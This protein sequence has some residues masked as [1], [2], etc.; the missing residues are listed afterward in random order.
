MRVEFVGGTHG[1][2]MRRAPINRRLDPP[3]IPYHT[4]IQFHLITVGNRHGY[5]T[6][7]NGFL[8]VCDVKYKFERFSTDFRTVFEREG[9]FCWILF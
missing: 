3:L 4:I 1:G 6:A 9:T 7:L 8:N 2:M 5:L